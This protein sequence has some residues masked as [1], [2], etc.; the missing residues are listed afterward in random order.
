MCLYTKQS[1]VLAVVLVSLFLAVSTE[2]APN[3]FD[4]EI[5]TPKPLKLIEDLYK[6][7]IHGSSTSSPNINLGFIHA[8][9]ASLSVI[10]VSELGD[11]TFFI[12]AI[13]AMRH[14]RV[15]VFVGAIA[16]L[17]LMTVLSVA[18]GMAATIIPRKWTYYIST[19]L[20]IIFGLKMLREGYK[21]SPN[22]AQEE[23]EEVQSDLRKRDDEL[24]KR[25]KGGGSPPPVKKYPTHEQ[26]LDEDQGLC[27]AS[28]SGEHL[29]IMVSP[30]TSSPSSEHIENLGSPGH[31][32]GKVVVSSSDAV[33]IVRVNSGNVAS[34]HVTSNGVEAVPKFE[35]EALTGDPE[36][37]KTYHA[38]TLSLLSRVVIQAFT[39]TFLAEWG[40]R[41]QLTT[42]ILAAREDA[43]GVALGGVLGHSFCT[44]LAVIGGRFIAQRISVRTVTI[45]GGVVFLVFALTA[46]LFDP[47]EDDGN[48][49]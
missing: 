45:T 20:F 47:T 21:M 35:K 1:Q 8:F 24:M 37:G 36:S 4:G 7:D 40:D 44:G 31:S 38:Q 39:L 19:I 30:L 42:I 43:Y 25:K 3:E 27:P 33:T 18:F 10:V 48:G 9:V 13:M 12:A 32:N 17:A 16:A 29:D 2:I 6:S 23:L 14:P 34:S 22:E 49:P 15:T 46:L 11:K 5:T 41:S 26:R 28:T